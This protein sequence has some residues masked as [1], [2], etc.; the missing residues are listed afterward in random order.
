[1]V[2][3]RTATTI[4]FLSQAA[5]SVRN[6]VTPGTVLPRLSALADLGFVASLRGAATIGNSTGV[7]V[8]PALLIL[9]QAEKFR[10]LI[11]ARALPRW[12]VKGRSTEGRNALVVSALGH[13]G[14][15]P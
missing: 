12:G 6:T 13:R 9:M 10:P 4:V 3:T 2:R 7:P 15:T 1:M 8:L 11:W 5:N 14:P